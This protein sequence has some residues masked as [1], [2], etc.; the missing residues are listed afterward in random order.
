MRMLIY[1]DQSEFLSPSDQ[2]TLQLDLLEHGLDL[3]QFY[4][5]ITAAIGA[6]VRT[7]GESTMPAIVFRNVLGLELTLVGIGGSIYH[8]FITL[9]LQLRP[10]WQQLQTVIISGDFTLCFHKYN[11]RDIQILAYRMSSLG[12]LM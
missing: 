11:Y 4:S 6:L 1:L 5:A 3:A 12:K 2:D 8:R 10:Q 9:L 7:N